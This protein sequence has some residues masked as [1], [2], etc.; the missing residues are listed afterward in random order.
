MVLSPYPFYQ[1]TVEMQRQ[2][3]GTHDRGG[4]R[5]ILEEIDSLDELE[6]IDFE[7][8]LDEAEV[9]LSDDDVFKVL[10]SRLR[11]DIIT[12]LLEEDGE[13]TV[14]DIAEYIAAEENETTI[15]QLSSYERKRVYIGL[16]Q[17]HLPMMDDIGVIEYDKNRGTV[18][19]RACVSQLEPYLG[20][21]DEAKGSRVT[22]GA[23]V[24]LA[25]MILLGILNLGMFALVPDSLWA[26]IGVTGLFGFT[27][28]DWYRDP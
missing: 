28:L 6:G 13:S 27:V 1:G 24:F 16:Y 14:S 11:R 8:G 12:Y 23:S 26:A 25:G 20:E 18:R 17:N 15:Q 5:E 7:D 19:L 2:A 10:Y 4:V 3:S 9:R 21:V 22:A